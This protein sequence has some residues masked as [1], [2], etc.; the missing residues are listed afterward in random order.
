MLWQL[1]LPALQESPDLSIQRFPSTSYCTP[2]LYWQCENVLKWNFSWILDWSKRTYELV[3]PFT[4]PNS[5]EFV[6][7]KF[8]FTDTVEWLTRQAVFLSLV[9]L[10]APLWSLYISMWPPTP[11]T[12]A[13]TCAKK[14]LYFHIFYLYIR[15]CL[16]YCYLQY[17]IVV[18]NFVNI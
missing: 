3:G 14:S 7:I 15:I 11:V 17:C 10:A 16:D 4:R 9:P 18:N 12:D 13:V 5:S 2:L 6:W 1:L 8:W